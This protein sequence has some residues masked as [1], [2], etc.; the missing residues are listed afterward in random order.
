M[1]N[2]ATAA[3]PRLS[4]KFATIEH[5]SEPGMTTTLFRDQVKVSRRRRRRTVTAVLLVVVVVFSAFTARLF[6]WPDLDPLPSRVDAVIELGGPQALDRDRVALELV[7]A[8]RAPVVV[9]STVIEEAGTDRCLP[10]VP[11]VTVLCFH[12]E[13]NTTRGEAE[14]IGRL[15]EERHWRSIVLITTP[16]QAWR[17]RLRFGRCFPGEVYVATAPLPAVSWFKQIPY[18]WVATAKAVI[19]E[20]SC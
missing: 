14:Y 10:P 7:R 16:D 15:A 17:A 5:A 6:I 2:N 19:V 18:H 11:G 4:C 13:P 3:A 12:A 8:H 1:I 9:Q 20:R